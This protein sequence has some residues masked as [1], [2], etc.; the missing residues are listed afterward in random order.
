MALA[1]D[2]AL[3]KPE[4]LTRYLNLVSFGNGA[5]GVQ[6][7]AKTYFGI[8]AADL[9]WQ[10]AALL[11]G[12]V[13]ST[14]SLN[15]YTN[16]AAALARRNLVLDTM[17]ENLPDQADELRQAR[18]QPLGILPQPAT[19]P[20]G[21]IAAGDRGFYLRL[22]PAVPGPGR[23]QQGGRGPQRL[24]DQDQAGPEGAEQRQAGHRHRGQP[25]AG[26]GR[27]RDER[28]PARR[29]R[30]QGARDGRQPRLRPQLAAGQTV[31]PQ[32]FSLVGDGAG[33]IF[34]IFTTAAALD[35]GMGINAQL[36]VPPT[37]QGKGLGTS[38]LPGCP[39]ETWCVKNAGA[40]RSPMSVT[41]ALAQSPNTAFAR[42]IQQVGVQRAVDMA[43]KLG[44][45][46]YAEPGTAR[47]YD[48]KSNE[49]LADYIKRQNLGSFTLGPFELNALEL[50][51][52]A[53]TLASGGMWCPP[54]PIDK[55]FDRNGKEVNVETAK[56]EQ[57]VPPGLANTLANALSKDATGGTAAGSAGSVGWTLPVS[58]KTG[59]T[60][61]HRSSGFLG[62]TNQYAAANYI[63]DDSTKPGGLCSFPLRKC[64]SGDLYGG[65]EPARTWFLAMQPDRH[66]LRSDR[67][68]AHRSALRRRRPG[69]R[70]AQR[71]RHGPGRGQEAG[72]RRRFPGV[73]PTDP[74]QQ[75]PL[76]GHDRR[77]H[78]EGQD[79][80]GVDHHDQHQQRDRPGPAATGVPAVAGRHSGP[81]ATA[82]GCATTA[83]RADHRHSRPAADHDPDDGPAAA[84]TSAGGPPATTGRGAATSAAAPGPRGAAA[85]AVA[86]CRAGMRTYVRVRRSGDHPAR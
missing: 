6:D 29:G 24:P 60:E 15:P 67:A 31:Q 12:M 2:K 16:S 52:V 53:A 20:E 61:S 77:H 44:L 68:A 49:S 37:F 27:Q 45:R 83:G 21:C 63:F 39:P 73:R 78:A 13:Q 84:A 56:C 71:H 32:P 79:H 81:A 38:N 7:A 23:D 10:Q 5:Y 34:K 72:A 11:A 65:K 9:N 62:F 55:V 76:E 36:E 40:Y 80:P 51:N 17:I 70:G 33:S 74:D 28:H 41:D 58:G 66:R 30:P 26:R 35:M 46:S 25:D 50:S 75:L 48:P 69:Q 3:S 59:T 64:G 19:L 22:R 54:S 86:I 18:E 85:T 57:V 42:L 4:I 14:S 47:A 82:T 1:L 8:D 43:V